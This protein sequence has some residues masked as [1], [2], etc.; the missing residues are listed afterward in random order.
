MRV[1]VTGGCGFIGQHVV[2]LLCA[3]YGSQSVYV[4]DIGDEVATGWGS[5]SSFIGN[6]L[7]LGDVCNAGDVSAILHKA[8]PD[9]VLHLAAQSHVD[10]SLDDPSSTMSTNA[11]GTQVVS[12]LC[13]RFGIRMLY[14]STDEVY[15]DC[16]LDSST[17]VEK[18]ED[19]TLNPSS[20]Y[21]ASK[22]AGELAVKASGRSLGL[23]Y[24]ITRGCNAWGMGQYNEKL[25]PIACRLL[26]KNKPVPIH[27]NGSQQRQWVHVSE[28]AAQL[29]FVAEGLVD[30]RCVGQTYNIAGP[31]ICSVLD[32]VKAI[33]RVADVSDSH[34][35]VT[36]RAGQDIAYAING[37]KLEALG[38]KSAI[39]SILDLSEIKD[40]LTAYGDGAVNLASYVIRTH[41]QENYHA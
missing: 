9:V 24:A 32:V 5:V 29:V 30:G 37:G 31:I 14:C 12:T 25:I 2:S 28:F 7:V 1:V 39:R 38:S 4:L 8:N 11:V 21:S 13:A 23:K 19:C 36:D 35:F 20:P 26:N 16:A 3:K 41:K 6:R 22:A 33:A 27:G 40:L 34:K 18:L 15:G 17:I 10:K